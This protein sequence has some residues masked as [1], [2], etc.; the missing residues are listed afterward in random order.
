[1]WRIEEIVKVSNKIQNNIVFRRKAV[2][3]AVSAALPIMLL[4]AA[5]QAYAACTASA[6]FLT[7]S[8]SGTV[9][10]PIDAYDAAAGFQPTAGGNGY[11]PANAAFPSTG[12]NPAP[13]TVI[14]NLDSTTLFNVTA[15]NGSGGGLNN[16]RGLI[17]ANYSN[18]EDPAV[19]NVTINNAG[20]IGLTA[21]GLGAGRLHAIV[22]DS[23]VNVLTVNNAASGN[24][25]VSQTFNWGGTFSAG[26]LTNTL[27]NL[28]NTAKYSGT[29]LAVVSGVYSDDNTESVVINNL[30]TMTATGNYAA[31]YYGRSDTEI[32]NS[33]TLQNASWVAGD[34]VTKGH[35]A[36]VNY[37]GADFATVDGSNPDTPLYKVVGGQLAIED[38]SALTVTNS[39]TIK[40]DILVLDT[41]PL[42]WA[43]AIA[44]GQT[45]STTS[46][47]GSNS[48]PKD[49]DIENS[50]TINGNIYLGSGEHV[51]NNSGSINGNISVDQGGG[52][53]AFAVA[54][55][56][57]GGMTYTSAG[58]GTLNS[59]GA[60]CPA[61]GTGT[62]DPFCA[63]TTNTLATF[64][65]ARSFS[66]TNTG[67]AIGGNLSITNTVATSLISISPAVTGSG[68]GSTQNAPS[69][70]IAGIT[71]TLTI[72]GA[73]PLD[74]IT[75]APT[76]GAGG[77][78]KS[79]DWFKVADAVAGGVLS[80]SDL[81]TITS[82]ALVTWT[83]AI[84]GSGNLVIGATVLSP[85]SIP[86]ISGSG[87][88]A[89]TALLG[90]GSSLGGTIQGLATAEEVRKAAEQLR[91]EIN[92]ASIQA[93][94]G[95]TGKVLDVIDSHLGETHLAQLTGNSGIATGDQANNAG[96]WIQGFGFRGD[97]DLRKSVDGYNADAYGFAAG[98][99]TALN[100]DTRVGAALSYAQSNIDAKGANT[101]NTT[102][103]DSYQATLYGSM[104]I[105]DWYLNAALGLARH[106]YDSKRLVVGNTVN[107]NHE[108]WQYTAKVD[109]GWP[110][111]FGKATVTPVASL[112][113]SRLSQDGYSENG[114]G[115]LNIGSQDTDSFRSGL[116]AKALIALRDK[117]DVTSSVEV[118]AIWS[119]EFADT[120]QDTTASF[121]TG[122][123]AFTSNGVSPARDSADLGASIRL[124]GSDGNIKQSLLISYDAEVKDEYLSHT[125]QLQAR[126]DF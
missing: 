37:A 108:A 14:I 41:N 46:G 126:F 120:A 20:T 90:S 106:D 92:G 42:S 40:G 94:L 55:A 33:G 3:I 87:A 12:Y 28:A 50:G 13:P 44:L 61:V 62:N 104:I 84:N 100:D 9:T 32:T 39:G 99:D 118:R 58:V 109:A 91:P 48:G 27:S 114:T 77:V 110:L 59:T 15:T 83:D 86:G 95:V 38:N 30:G 56:G 43:A 6:N 71:G 64:A 97:Q 7:T 103:I 45:P 78:V 101:G 23:Q 119:H 121:T 2:H 26:N 17:T 10:A 11:V 123:A 5:N 31:V 82:S 53:G 107:G 57:T 70:N 75:L 66:L 93:A 89:I 85:T 29:N 36:I 69:A 73:I 51:I 67:A 88:N 52:T 116:G 19:N 81:P 68:A 113:Y 24:I 111:Q 122:G 74:N 105:K 125:A 60:A 16:D 115:A 80:S 18:S 47:S 117:G 8:C 25:N 54:N 1:M 76:I 21:I 72:S 102:D 4:G 22:G 35:W 124:A 65:G 49:S 96:V 34:A 63:A 98:A 79:G 112:A